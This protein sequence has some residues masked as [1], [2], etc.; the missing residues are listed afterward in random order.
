[1]QDIKQLVHNCWQISNLPFE[2]SVIT[3]HFITK[4]KVGTAQSIDYRQSCVEMLIVY[5]ITKQ[6]EMMW[7]EVLSPM[8]Q[9]I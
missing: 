9:M 4:D 2:E 7:D 3:S 1:M 6:I 8:L 5:T